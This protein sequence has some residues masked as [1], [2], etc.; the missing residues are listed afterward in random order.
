[1]DGKFLLS[2]GDIDVILT[3]YY[4]L[5]YPDKK[6]TCCSFRKEDS[7]DDGWGFDVKYYTLA[8]NLSVN[9]P[10]TILGKLHE[11]K[12]EKTLYE[13]ELYSIIKENL[14]KTL[15]SV[16]GYNIEVSGIKAEKNN[17]VIHIKEKRKEKV[18]KKGD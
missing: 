15:A 7:Y 11:L 10:A 5:L 18:L 3:E 17:V 16:E 2:Y 14:D 13:K 12:C 9:G 6:V 8:A 1:M 4:K